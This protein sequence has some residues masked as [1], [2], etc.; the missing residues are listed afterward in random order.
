MHKDQRS[1]HTWHTLGYV[2]HG[3]VVATR[4]LGPRL[5]RQTQVGTLFEV[6]LTVDWSHYNTAIKLTVCTL[7]SQIYA[8][9]GFCLYKVTYLYCPNHCYRAE[10]QQSV[11]TCVSW[12]RCP[13]PPILA[14]HLR[15]CATRPQSLYDLYYIMRNIIN[16]KTHHTR[17]FEYPRVT[18]VK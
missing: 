11:K 15:D 12:I 17:K 10:Y 9:L 6:V 8:I 5:E 13:S 14:Q 2:E 3:C 4:T 16:N 1:V 18:S 7:S